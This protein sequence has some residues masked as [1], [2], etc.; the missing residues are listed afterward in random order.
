MSGKRGVW[1]HCFWMREFPGGSRLVTIVLVP[2]ITC[3]GHLQQSTQMCAVSQAFALAKNILSLTVYLRPTDTEPSVAGP[4]YQHLTKAQDE[5]Y[6][7]PS[8]I[9]KLELV[10]ILWYLLYFWKTSHEWP[11][12]ISL[13][14]S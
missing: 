4:N 3:H 7:M 11:I 12:F 10:L 13:L 9:L 5:G 6:T 2:V 1:L 14:K 8:L